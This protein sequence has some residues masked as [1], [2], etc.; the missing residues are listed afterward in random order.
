LEI[1]KLT[2]S[3]RW[4]LTC[5][6]GEQTARSF[7]NSRGIVHA[8]NFEF[9]YWKGMDGV[10]QAFPEMFR[11]FVTKQVSHFC[12]TKTKCFPPSTEKIKNQCLNR[13]SPN[14]ITTHITRCLDPGR[15]ACFVKLVESIKDWLKTTH[16][17]D[18]LALCITTYLLK[19][20]CSTM[21]EITRNLPTFYSFATHHD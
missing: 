10:M 18:G 21:V 16:T 4:Q 5:Y 1:K 6:W 19:R 20:G 11:V 13:G 9:I 12:A 8:H 7:F 17:G 3:A 15:S 14:E 2:G